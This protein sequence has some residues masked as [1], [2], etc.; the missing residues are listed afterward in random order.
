MAIAKLNVNFTKRGKITILGVLLVIVMALGVVNL[1]RGISHPQ[2]TSL[3]NV[4][5]QGVVADANYQLV[6]ILDLA[7]NTGKQVYINTSAT[8]TLFFAT[9]DKQ[10]P[11]TIQSIQDSLNKMGNTPHKPLVLVSTFAKTTDQQKAIAEAKAFQTKNNVTL[12]IT[13]QVGPPTEFVQQS[14]SLVYTD[15]KGTHIITDPSQ[16]LDT[17]NSV[18]TLS[19][20]QAATPQANANQAN[21]TNPSASTTPTAP[22][23]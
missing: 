15:D 2:G 22:A 19:K 12:P 9:W 4:P 13:V 7:S 1:L 21:G 20:P 16:M 18:L 11:K 3:A 10:V 23:K 17:L 14:P 6:P 8:P 5:L